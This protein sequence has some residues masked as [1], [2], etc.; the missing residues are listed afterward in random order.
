MKTILACL[1]VL[2]VISMECQNKNEPDQLQRELQAINISRG[3]IALCGSG[4]F[5]R[6]DFALSCKDQVQANFN[7]ATA[8]LHSFEYTEAEKVF[9]KVIDEDPQCLMAYW[10]VAMSNFHPL[11]APPGAEEL[12]KGSKTIALARSLKTDSDR[13]KEYVE[14]IAT[15]FDGWEKLDHKTRVEKFVKASQA[16]YA[17]YPDDKEA[18]IFYALA[19]RSSADPADKSFEKQKKAGEI[20]SKLFPDEPDHPGIAHYLIH[21][22]DYPELAELGLPAARK[23]ASIAANSAHA[24]HMPSHIFTRLGL[25]DESIQSNIKSTQAAKCYAENLGKKGHWD[26]ELH[27]LDYLVYAYLQEGKDDQAKEQVTYLAAIDSVFPITF[28]NAYTFAATPVRYAL[29]RKDWRQAANLELHPQSFPWDKFLWQKAI[30]H[31]G[32]LIGA[33]HIRDIKN[34]NLQLQELRQIQSALAT[35]KKDYEANQVHIQIKSGEAWISFL[36]GNKTAAIQFMIEAAD[37]EDATEKHA[38]TPGEVVPARELLGDMYMEL[39]DYTK[40][41]EAYRANLKKRP[42]RF[43]SIYGAALAAKK[44]GDHVSA[45]TYFEQLTKLSQAG[46]KSRPELKEAEKFLKGV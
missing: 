42:G 39:G 25:W 44:S 38:V 3:E 43:N 18:A 4:Q 21:N 1:I 41:A 40:A 27:G 7:L 14:A 36:N 17:K 33:V 19:L 26:Q 22:Y 2:A 13:E 45:K 15:I 10:G 32:K 34:A 8:L 37:M 11:W 12:D 24:Q 29:E 6:V 46:N 20:L 9:A 5:G 31:F 35:A 28:V 30:H 23:Y 16:I